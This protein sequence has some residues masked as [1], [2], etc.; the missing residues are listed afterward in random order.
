MLIIRRREGEGILVGEGVEIRV[1]EVAG[2][3]VSLGISAPAEVVILRQELYLAGRHN[4]AAARTADL[5]RLPSL[6]RRFEG[7]ARNS[8]ST[9]RSSHR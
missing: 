7:G 5:R 6:V 8:S 2:G 4:E 3:R 9:S 1:L